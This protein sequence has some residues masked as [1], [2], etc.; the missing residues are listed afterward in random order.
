[1]GGYY[2]SPPSA[3]GQSIYSAFYLQLAGAVLRPAPN[4]AGRALQL[5][6]GVGTAAR[7]L[8]RANVTT[9]ECAF[10]PI[11]RRLPCACVGLGQML[12]GRALVSARRTSR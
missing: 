10:V 3:A 8:I 5:G 1:M 6:L 4:G 7:S 2:T 12:S 11:G 9:G